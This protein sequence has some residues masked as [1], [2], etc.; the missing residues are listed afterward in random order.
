ML[1]IKNEW[2]ELLFESEEYGEVVKFAKKHKKKNNLKSIKVTKKSG[3][4]HSLI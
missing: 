2:G 1:Q 3:E 4:F